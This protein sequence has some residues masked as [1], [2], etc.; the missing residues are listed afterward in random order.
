MNIPSPLPFLLIGADYMGNFSP[1]WKCRKISPAV[2]IPRAEI[3]ILHCQSCDWQVVT[4]DKQIH[5]RFEESSL[6]HLDSL[7]KDHYT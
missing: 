1:G 6:F 2:H 5:K 7:S 4:V 3:V